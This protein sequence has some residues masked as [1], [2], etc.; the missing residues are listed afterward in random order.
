MK[1][2]FFVRPCHDDVVSYL[3]Y[4]SKTLLKESN[5]KGFKTINKDKENANKTVVTSVIKK[6]NPNF[7]MFNGHGSP[8]MIC[9]H[10]DEVLI[11]KGKNH[12]LIKNRIIYSLSCSSAS[13]L[14][15]AVVD[16]KTTF[17][18]YVD[19]FA[20]G[21]DMNSQ[22][23]VHKDERAKLFLEPSNLLVKS[24]LKGNS[25]KDAVTKAKNLMKVNISK[26]KTDPFPDA[27]DYLPYL[28][29]NY[30]ILEVMGDESATL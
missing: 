16:S 7:I 21:M 10:R 26:L 29:N 3:Y 24:L 9:G 15:T 14:G 25:A 12:N 18:G 1:K 6:N 30:L 28:Y 8:T 2:T 5:N 17:I 20:L 23:V 11:E 19:E 27:K 4:Y 13:Q 22:A